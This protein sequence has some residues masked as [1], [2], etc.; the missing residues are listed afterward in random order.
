VVDGLELATQLILELCGGEP[1][2]IAIAGA[3]PPPRSPVEFDPAYVKR[4]AGLDLPEARITGVLEALGFSLSGA[5]PTIIVTPPTW[6]RD[7]DGAADLVEEVARISGFDALP[8]TPLPET[9]FRPGGV[10]TARQARMRIARRAMAAMGYQETIGWSFTSQKAAILFGGG[11]A[12]LVLANP[13]ASEL[14]CMRPSALPGLIEAAGRNAARGFADVALF[15][16][17]PVFLGDG[18]N[19]QRTTVAG[20]VAPHG[21]RRWDGGADADL[22]ALK[23]E[24]MAL[25]EEL[26]APTG[27]LQLVQ[28]PAGDWWRPG[29]AAKLQLGPKAVLA[30][31]GEIHPR[32]LKAMDVEGPILGF[33]LWL[34]AIP[35]PKKRATKARAPL[36]LSPLMP[37]RR[38]FAFLIDQ[39][40]PAG[41][42]VRAAVAA[43]KAL[44]ADAR[45]FDVYQGKGVEDG[46]K[47]V[48]IE[49]V[50]QPRDKTLTEAEIEALSQAIVAS[51]AKACGARLRS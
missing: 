22:Y 31:F 26:G 51:A 27:P 46:F 50:I 28:Q 23:G 16:I 14:D 38:D 13:I 20:I 6:R 47:S 35:E 10:L 36:S 45:V 49:V 21:P 11:D 24:L 15:E 41:E 34:E 43:D 30:A 5:A 44:I 1:S 32:V 19:D 37:L 12:R 17:G 2:E 18:P 48:A 39:D 9:A 8:S 33:E 29:R 3:P 4:L 42:L 7:V 25:L 40:R